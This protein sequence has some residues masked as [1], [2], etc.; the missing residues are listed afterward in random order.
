MEN[1]LMQANSKPKKC[2][3]D[4]KCNKCSKRYSFSLKKKVIQKNKLEPSLIKMEMAC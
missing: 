4:S 1:N 3:Q 2:L